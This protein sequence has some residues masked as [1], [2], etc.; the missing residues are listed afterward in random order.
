MG[1]ARG[2]FVGENLAAG[3]TPGGS[4]SMNVGACPRIEMV[5]V[6][7]RPN[8]RDRLEALRCMSRGQA[9]G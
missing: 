6:N 9:R 2:R 8:R 1:S 7:L 3:E 5:K 4:R